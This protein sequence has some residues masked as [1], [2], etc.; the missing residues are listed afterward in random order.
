MAKPKVDQAVPAPEIP[1]AADAAAAVETGDIP[2]PPPASASGASSAPSAAS[3]PSAPSAPSSSAGAPSDDD[4]D[5]AEKGKAPPAPPEF[6]PHPG[7]HRKARDPLGLREATD[8]RGMV[9]VV[10]KDTGQRRKMWPIDARYAIQAGQVD[11][12]ED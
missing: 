10:E 6:T 7:Q 8:G 2:G 3:A 12:V 1:A 5:G 9:T 4:Q 11:L